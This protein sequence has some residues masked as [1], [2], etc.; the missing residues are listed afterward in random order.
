MDVGFIFEPNEHHAISYNK[1]IVKS[2]ASVFGVSTRSSRVSV[3]TL[4]KHPRLAITFHDH[5]DI[6]S[7]NNAVDAIHQ[8]RGG[9]SLRYLDKSLMVARDEM[10]NGGS[11]G[12]SKLL[13]IVKRYVEDR[14]LPFL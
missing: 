10:F 6:T 8:S 14:Y 2:L 3:I 13:V 11:G 7:F 9:D 4:Q 12:S 1:Y 5:T